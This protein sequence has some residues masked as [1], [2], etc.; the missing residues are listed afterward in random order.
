MVPQPDG[1]DLV[2]S[3]D[4]WRFPKVKMAMKEKRFDIG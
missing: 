2:A 4:V 3:G 1:P